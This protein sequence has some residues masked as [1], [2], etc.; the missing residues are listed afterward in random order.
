[1]KG[2]PNDSKCPNCGGTVYRI[3]RRTVDRLLSVMTPVR[4][5]RCMALEWA[6]PRDLREHVTATH[7]R[8]LNP[9]LR[10]SDNET[11]ADGIYGSLMVPPAQSSEHLPMRGRSGSPFT[12]P[13]AIDAQ[14]PGAMS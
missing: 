1:M 9:T 6:I 11:D 2:I 13:A 14:C 7:S 4:R 3:S 10:M 8:S 12:I 5:Y